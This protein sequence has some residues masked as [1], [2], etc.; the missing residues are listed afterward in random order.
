MFLYVVEVVDNKRNMG[1]ADIMAE[2]VGVTDKT[3]VL[4]TEV[5]IK[6]AIK[7]AART[8]DFKLSSS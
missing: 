6:R 3:I 5:S 1:L 8:R 7:P 2:S 4:R